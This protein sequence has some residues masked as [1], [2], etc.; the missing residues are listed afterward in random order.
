MSDLYEA[1]EAGDLITVRHLTMDFWYNSVNSEVGSG[2]KLLHVACANGHIKLAKW[3]LDMGCDIDIT[4]YFNNT[5]LHVASREG[6]T[7]I[8]KLLLDYGININSMSAWWGMAPIHF[9]FKNGHMGTVELLLSNGAE[10]NLISKWSFFKWKDIEPV[11][12]KFAI[13]VEIT[14]LPEWRPWNHS[15]YPTKYR[16]TMR[17]LV[18]L[19]KQL[20]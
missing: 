4:D 16:S 18:L 19:A 14:K 6:Y 8:V 9:A 3:L 1:C 15:K 7:D 10:M 20:N 11:R 17:T 13:Y 2:R 12:K 5:P